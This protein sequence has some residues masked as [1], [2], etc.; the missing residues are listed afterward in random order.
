MAAHPLQDSIKVLK[1][2]IKQL[3]GDFTESENKIKKLNANIDTLKI[4]KKNESKKKKKDVESWEDSI[5]IIKKRGTDGQEN[6]YN[7]IVRKYPGQLEGT[8]DLK[9]VDD[10]ILY[11]QKH[12]TAKQVLAKRYN[13]EKVKNNINV[14]NKLDRR[15]STI[16]LI[17]LLEGYKE[18]NENLKITIAKIIEIT[19]DERSQTDIQQERKREKI[20]SVL[21][22]YVSENGLDKEF[23]Y[24]PYLFSIIL[25]I[26]DIKKKDG[27]DADITPL[28]EKL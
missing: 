1:A 5:K 6:T 26:M 11:I 23:S 22:Q 13:E 15:D 2:T 28:L 24:Y 20:L 8:T 10:K 14:L 9:S 7:E 3:E 17:K 4:N 16:K 19:N 25:E 21:S 27:V 18:Y 12:Y